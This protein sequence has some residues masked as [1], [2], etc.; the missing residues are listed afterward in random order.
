MPLCNRIFPVGTVL[1]AMIA[2]NCSHVA[3]RADVE[4]GAN[5]SLIAAPSRETYDPPDPPDYEDT[6]PPTFEPTYYDWP[7]FIPTNQVVDPDVEPQ[8]V[9]FWHP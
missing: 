9:D 4:E 8:V 5:V 1:S 2:I 7:D 6:E 3:H